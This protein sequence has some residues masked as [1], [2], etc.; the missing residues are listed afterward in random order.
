MNNKI[1]ELWA[2]VKVS[3]FGEKV[4]AMNMELEQG[5]ETLIPF[6]GA[7]KEGLVEDF[8]PFA[9]QHAKESNEPVKLIRLSQ[10]D[11]IEVIK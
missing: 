6:I 2:Y 4:I 9:E 11:E 3:E 5:R 10:R 8:R 7:D 1:T